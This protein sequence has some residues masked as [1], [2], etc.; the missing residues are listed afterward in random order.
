MSETRKAGLSR[1]LLLTALAAVAFAGIAG[2]AL[3]YSHELLQ[4][5]KIELD[6]ARSAIAELVEATSEMAQ[7]SAQLDTV[8]PLLEKARNAINNFPEWS[9]DPRIVQSRARTYLMLAEINLDRGRV[10]R[11]NADATEAY[12]S[13]ERLAKSGN[14]E[15]RHM[16][17]QAGRLSGAANWERSNNDEARR[18]YERGIAG[19]NEILKLETDP[20]IIWRW[21]RSLADLYQALGDVLLARFD[22]PSEALEAFEQSRLL[23]IRIMDLGHQGPAFEYDLAWI[24]NKRGEV[25]NQLGNEDAALKWFVEARDRLAN[26]KDRIWD[27]PRWAIDLG[28]IYSNIG[29]LK[30]S[31]SRFAEGVSQ[32]AHAEDILTSVYKRDPKSLE[33]S[34]ALNWCRFV[35]A[36]NLFRWALAKND[37]ILMLEVREQAISIADTAANIVKQAPE[38]TQEQLNKVRGEAFR[39]SIDATLRQWNGN[40]DSAALGFIEAVD[41]IA[42]DYLPMAAKMPSRELLADNVQYLEWAGMAYAKGQKTPEAQAFF[43]RALEMLSEY[44]AVLGE[45]V[46]EEHRQRIAARVDRS[47]VAADRTPLPA[48][49]SA[50]PLAADNVPPTTGGTVSPPQQ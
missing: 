27:N 39:A 20:K 46:Y 28:T 45:K 17:A 38:R 22:K 18:Q 49:E 35:R 40:N 37:R 21:M 19:L 10:D 14:L 4:E 12:I 33:R 29:M 1:W 13:L 44:R 6:N 42:K 5:L 34:A 43:K 16:R 24:T 7:S 25:E 30:R 23:R 48:A 31:Q 9:T 32:F 26:L 8:E 36:E 3:Y 11:A 15:A 47:P 41:I 2:Y 50:S